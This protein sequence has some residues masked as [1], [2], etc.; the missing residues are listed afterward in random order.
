MA[1]IYDLV[2]NPLAIYSLPLHTVMTALHS[3]LEANYNA[4]LP[5]PSITIPPP[6]LFDNYSPHSSGIYHLPFS[7]THPITYPLPERTSLI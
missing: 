1:D 7:H 5:C 2:E 4:Q 6:P 3:T